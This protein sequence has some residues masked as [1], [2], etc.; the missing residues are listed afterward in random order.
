M[1]L[2]QIVP[3]IRQVYVQA[4]QILFLRSLISSTIVR[5]RVAKK[6]NPH[7]VH[8]SIGKGVGVMAPFL[9]NDLTEAKIHLV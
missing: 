6:I 9:F 8:R 4:Q 2:S 3:S 1:L 5:E 7:T